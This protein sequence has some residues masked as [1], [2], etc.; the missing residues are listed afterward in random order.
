MLTAAPLGPCLLARAG[1]EVNFPHL[2]VLTH[3]SLPPLCRSS[4]SSQVGSKS[5]SSSTLRQ[6]WV[7]ESPA[8]AAWLLNRDTASR[9]K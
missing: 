8:L 6:T 3:S 2:Y 9:G 4:D 1:R 5:R 7:C